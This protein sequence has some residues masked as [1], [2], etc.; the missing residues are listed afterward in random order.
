ML[1]DSRPDRTP[2]PL[3]S[4]PCF[5][6]ERHPATSGVSAQHQQPTCLLP[7]LHSLSA[8]QY[9][10]AAL[11]QSF[12]SPS[13]STMTML[14]TRSS[15]SES[16]PGQAQGQQH[17]RNSQM[18]RNIY[19]TPM[20]NVVTSNYR[21]QTSNLPAAPYA[22]TSTPLMQNAQNPLRQHPTTMPPRLEHRT[23]SAPAVPLLQQVSS[24]GPPISNRPRPPVISAGST[25][26][27]SSQG[28]AF[29]PQSNPISSN[30]GGN[31][32]TR[33]V[34][35]LDFIPPNLS[36]ANVA[37]SSPDRYKRNHQR[38]QTSSA[39]LNGISSQAGSAG[40]S[41]SGMATVGHLYNHPTQTSSTPA[42]TSYSSYRGTVTPQ[43]PKDAENFRHTSKDDTTIQ[44]QSA[45][46]L[47]KR[48]RRRSI[49]S[50]EAKEYGIPASESVPIVQS[51][52]K[53]YAGA[54]Q[55]PIPLKE[56]RPIPNVE[57]PTSS[58]G[59]NA[60][61][62]SSNSGRSISRPA[63][64]RFCLNFIEPSVLL[65]LSFFRD[66]LVIKLLVL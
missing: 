31:Q 40:P 24:Q 26:L 60:S 1:S 5:I 51:Q 28:T 38:A 62:E 14:Q 64:V 33:P 10:M 49:S 13:T 61:N 46:E 59:R 50:L 55:A 53:T 41:G 18:P 52:P 25:P 36:Y 63:S 15:P 19:N 8:S 56:N 2:L 16:F 27:N 6:L 65:S 23:S 12:P 66:V 17:Q 32:S 4:K 21:G 34:S 30:F 48:Y 35:T 9:M 22:F 39:P 57:R 47:A 43:I 42:L 29:T 7:R 3:H 58:H 20:G 54:L 11:V 45:S 37:K 44:R